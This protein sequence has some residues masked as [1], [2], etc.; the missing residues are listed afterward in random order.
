MEMGQRETL[1][2]FPFA[3]RGPRANTMVDLCAP[4]SSHPEDDALAIH[5]ADGKPQRERRIEPAGQSRQQQVSPVERV[6]QQA[7]RNVK[8][9]FRIGRRY[10]QAAWDQSP[11]N[12]DRE[13]LAAPWKK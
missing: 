5:Q 4:A 11:T 10:A 2:H 6:E 1:P 7:S 12:S 9:A 13:Q 3:R 8:N